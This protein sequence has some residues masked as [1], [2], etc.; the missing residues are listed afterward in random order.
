M[1]KSEDIYGDEQCNALSKAISQCAKDEGITV[2]EWLEKS[3]KTSMVV[4]LIDKL[5]ELG[6]EIKKTLV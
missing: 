4:L 6:Y 5:N 2:Y 3:G 1:S